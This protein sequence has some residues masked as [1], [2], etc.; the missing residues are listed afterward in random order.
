LL[1]EATVETT[2]VVA[3]GATTT[4]TAVEEAL[5][6]GTVMKTPLEM[7]SFVVRD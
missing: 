5:A 3:V 6:T 7:V 1:A 2:R 4:G